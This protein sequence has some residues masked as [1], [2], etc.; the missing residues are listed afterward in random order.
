MEKDKILYLDDEQANLKAFKA[1]FR[2]EFEIETASSGEKALELCQQKYFKVVVSDQRMPG[3]SGAEFFGRLKE[4]D[5]KAIRILITA[6][7]DPEGLKNAINDGKVY[8]FIQKPFDQDEMLAR[9]RKAVGDYDFREDH[10]DLELK[11]ERIEKEKVRAVLHNLQNQVNPHFLFNSLNMLHALIGKDQDQARSYVLQLSDFL[12]KSL[13]YRDMDLA[14]LTEEIELMDKYIYIQKIRFGDALQFVNKLRPEDLDEKIPVMA[15]QICAENAIKHN[16][17]SKDIPLEIKIAS[18]G[19]EVIIANNWN[20]RESS[21]PSTGVGQQNLL[22]RY[23]LFGPDLPKFG[24]DDEN[25]ICELPFL[26]TK[27]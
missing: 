17:M 15:V 27:S 12:R 13:E 9:L 25:Y 14:S 11:A 23:R 6:Y 4:I 3:M 2:H 21:S 26:R 18:N 1:S 24:H 20:P 22:S 19:S 8:Y 16:R 5:S 10:Q 7:S